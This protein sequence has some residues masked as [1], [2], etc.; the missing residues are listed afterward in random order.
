MEQ[1]IAH[2]IGDYILQSHDMAVNKV[3]SNYWALYHAVMYSLPF[4]FLTHNLL[5]LFIA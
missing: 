4:V 2:L 5:A 3:R 1:L